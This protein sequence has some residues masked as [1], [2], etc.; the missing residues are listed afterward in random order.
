MAQAGPAQGADDDDA[1]AGINHL[2]PGILHWIFELLG[3]RDLARASGVCKLWRRLNRD[4]ASNA[5]WRSFYTARW[6]VF[7]APEDTCWQSLYGSKMKEVRPAAAA[8]GGYG[9]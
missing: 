8:G 5:Q 9:G 4:K 3:P 2:P 6:R 1:G 7:G